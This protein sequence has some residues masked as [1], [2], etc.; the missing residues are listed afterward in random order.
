MKKIVALVLSLVMALSLCTVAFGAT[1]E[2]NE[3]LPNGKIGTKVADVKKVAA[4]KPA[5]QE[6]G[7]IEYYAGKDAAAG[8]YYIPCD[9]DDADVAIYT[10]HQL[11]FEN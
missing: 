1:I 4:K 2:A 10:N 6:W 7:W 11:T 5:G 8:R 3:K 9:K